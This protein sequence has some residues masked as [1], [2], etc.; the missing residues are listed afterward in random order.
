MGQAQ[1]V[2]GT[3]HTC[4]PLLGK[5]L[6]LPLSSI[7]PRRRMFLPSPCH[8][9]SATRRTCQSKSTPRVFPSS[10][11]TLLDPSLEIEEETLPT[12]YPEKYQV[13]AKLGY[14]VTCT[15]WFA[16]DLIDS[17][18]VALKIYVLGQNRDHELGIYERLNS[19][20]SNHPGK[21]F[22]RKLLGHFYT[23]GPH[24]RHICLVHELLGISAG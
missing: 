13:L 21:R 10:G 19:V 15:V 20:E 24:G 4:A 23:D 1:A 18:Y 6:G 12:Y 9:T 5:A 16:R 2:R 8:I 14:G 3:R 7:F 17:K 11:F 22:I